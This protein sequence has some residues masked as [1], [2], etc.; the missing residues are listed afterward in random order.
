MFP[1][2][3]TQLIL[4]MVVCLFVM[5]MICVGIGIYILIAKVAGKELRVIA[6]QTARLAQKGI[7]D[8]VVGM[9]GNASALIDALNQL[10]R[11]ASGVGIFLM[12]IGFV[13][14]GASYYLVLQVH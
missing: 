7:A 10:V 9:V 6:N 4:T 5:G 11:T 1:L 12:L 14:L 3:V 2:A 8:D 13:F